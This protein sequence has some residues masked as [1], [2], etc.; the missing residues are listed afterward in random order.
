[1]KK[2]KIY[3]LLI[4]TI[5][6]INSCENED[7]SSL[8]EDATTSIQKKELE[9]KD[10]SFVNFTEKYG[11]T[12]RVKI[13]HV[14]LGRKSRNCFRF[15]ICYVCALCEGKV[16][17]ENIA[18]ALV[19]QDSNGKNSYLVLELSKKI[20]SLYDSNLY[21]DEDIFSEQYGATIKN[22]VYLLDMTIGE[23]GGYKV[24]FN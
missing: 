3:V 22:G 13:L 5:F 17:S 23:F 10:V 4:A 20:N 24:L 19:K 12:S 7:N 18:E 2:L 1:M 6:I 21:V 8:T 9:A 15:G 14:H 11:G 16:S